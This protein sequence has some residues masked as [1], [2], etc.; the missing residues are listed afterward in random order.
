MLKVTRN[1]WLLVLLVVL[2]SHAALTIHSG[3]HLALDKQNCELCTQQ[4][5]LAH[6]VPPDVSSSFDFRQFAPQALAPIPVPSA[7]A[8]VP[9]HQRAPPRHA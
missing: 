8:F 3:T 7:E 4:A 5:N 1:Q 2:I 9:Y 6:A